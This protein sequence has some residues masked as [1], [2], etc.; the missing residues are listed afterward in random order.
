FSADSKNFR[1]ADA[2]RKSQLQPPGRSLPKI[3]FVVDRS[4][5]VSLL[6]ELGTE[7]VKT[8]ITL[9]TQTDS[10][11]ESLPFLP[12]LHFYRNNIIKGPCL[13]SQLTRSFVASTARPPSIR[14]T[15]MV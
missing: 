1:R 8:G 9:P 3:Y 10:D 11:S 4:Q 6:G 5:V 13:I 14:T 15:R 12:C 2:G 7:N